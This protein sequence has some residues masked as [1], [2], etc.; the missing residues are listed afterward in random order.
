MR[1]GRDAGAIMVDDMNISDPSALMAMLDILKTKKFALRGFYSDVDA[2]YNPWYST[3]NPYFENYSNTPENAI[4]WMRWL[5]RPFAM[6]N[7]QSIGGQLEF[8]LGSFPFEVAYY[9]LQ[10]NSAWWGDSP[11]AQTSAFSSPYGSEFEE[12]PYDGL[13]SV[14]VKK[15]VADGVTL[16]L[17]YAMQSAN[18]NFDEELDN[19][20]LL[21][22]QVSLGF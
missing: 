9:N 21:S 18:E 13:F 5:D 1:D 20:S 16:G 19:A 17:T 6:T 15:Q 11:Y 8:K 14:R 3:V 22:A 7:V 12:I 2:A 4:P 10:A